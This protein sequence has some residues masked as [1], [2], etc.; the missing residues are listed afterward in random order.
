MLRQAPLWIDR[1]AFLDEFTTQFFSRSRCSA[2]SQRQIRMFPG[3]A[4]TT[5]VTL[6]VPDP[7]RYGEAP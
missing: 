7:I 3:D 2:R 4:T 1:I 6:S 5:G